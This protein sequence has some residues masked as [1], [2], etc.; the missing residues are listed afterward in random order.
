MG[1]R[2]WYV[3][4]VGRD[5]GVFQT[6]LEVSPLVTGVSGALHQSFPTEE[7]A[8]EIF[9]LEQSR[10]HVRTVPPARTARTRTSVP[11]QPSPSSQSPR[12]TEAPNV[13]RER[14]TFSRS[15]PPL[16]RP[17]RL[18]AHPQSQPSSPLNLPPVTAKREVNSSPSLFPSSPPTC[19]T[20]VISL[21]SGPLSPIALRE[22]DFGLDPDGSHHLSSDDLSNFT[23]PR[24]VTASVLV[25]ARSNDAGSSGPITINVTVP[26]QCVHY[27]A[28]GG[29]SAPSVE[30]NFDSISSRMTALSLGGSHIPSGADPRSPFAQQRVTS[31]RRPSPRMQGQDLS[32]MLFQS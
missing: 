8:H 32:S 18:P 29:H 16:R 15:P 12:E 30:E 11:A 21:S 7:E 31:S 17:P 24:P 4:T 27:G 10:G 6:W 23:S 14:Q 13:P 3:V 5:V 19:V 1:K 22:N 2:K 28:R 9:L 20:Q 26:V 25:P